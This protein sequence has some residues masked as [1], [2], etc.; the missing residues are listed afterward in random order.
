M[1]GRGGRERVAKGWRKGGGVGV[2]C[3]V[4]G[5]SGVGVVCMVV[6]VV[7]VWGGGVA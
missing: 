3:M 1:G 2:V 7:C 4:D 5:A 6:V